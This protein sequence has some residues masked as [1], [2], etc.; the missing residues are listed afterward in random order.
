MYELVIKDMRGN[1]SIISNNKDTLAELALSEWEEW[2]YCMA[3]EY[4]Q[5]PISDET[6]FD[7]IKM[8]KD[9]AHWMF[10][11]TNHCYIKE[12]VYYD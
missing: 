12:V 3:Y 7:Q 11:G 9:F 6:V 8:A 10:M 5:Y 2:I 4:M 1:Y